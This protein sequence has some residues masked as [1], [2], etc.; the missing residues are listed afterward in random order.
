MK[1]AVLFAGQGSQVPGMGRD[2]YDRYDR[3]RE[4]FDLLPEEQ[5]RI[6]FEG[7]EEALRDTVNT[8]P[9]LLAFGLGV[10][11]VL[12]DHGFRADFAAGL[13]LGEYTALAAAGVFQPEQAVRLIQFRADHMAEA[14]KGLDIAMSA[15][16][17]LDEENE[18]E[19]CR[20]ASADGIV[21]PANFNC[22]GQIVISGESAAV[23]KAEQYAKEAGAKRCMRLP[24][25]GPFHTSFMDPAG[26]ALKERFETESFGEPAFPVYFNATGETAGRS[27]IPDLLVRQVSHPVRFEQ[28]IRN[29]IAEG[30]EQ[31]VEIGPGKTLSG[32]VRRTDRSKKTVTI[33]TADELEAFIGQLA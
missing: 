7:P 14:S 15:V 17:G 11:Q 20:R 26:K 19:C 13:S 3:F 6:A 29:L 28:I 27:E 8:Q 9:I 16:L 23:E 1:R 32:F 31:F 18:T 10:W 22:P 24:V 21:E 4:I 25:S 30:T 33:E 5:K 2:L 12:T